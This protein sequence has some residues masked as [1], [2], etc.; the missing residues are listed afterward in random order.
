MNPKWTLWGKN[1]NVANCHCAWMFTHLFSGVM[2]QLAATSGAQQHST[3]S[4]KEKKARYRY[5]LALIRVIALQHYSASTKHIF[6]ATIHHS[7]IV[8]LLPRLTL[9]VFF[10]FNK[11]LSTITHWKD[12]FLSVSKI[13]RISTQ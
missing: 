10:T 1:Y 7:L 11:C 13:H 6:N 8:P 4:S 5:L 12:K 9:L 2:L 3:A